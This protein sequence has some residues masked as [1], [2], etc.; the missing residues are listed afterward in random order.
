MTRSSQKGF[1]LTEVVICL[2][3]GSMV[4]GAVIKVMISNDVTLKL[5][6][7]LASVQENGRFGI[8]R[9]RADLLYTGMYQDRPEAPADAFDKGEEAQFVRH[10]PVILPGTFTKRPQLGSLQGEAGASDTLVVARQSRRDCRGYTLGYDG[11][12]PVFI[13]NEYYVEGTALKCRGFDGRFLRGQKDAEGHNRHAGF[14]LLDDVYSFQVLYGQLIMADENEPV[15]RYVTADNIVDKSRIVS[16]RLAL[17][18]KGDG[19]VFIDP[20]PAFSLLNESPFTPDENRLFKQFET[21]IT[22]RNVLYMN[23]LQHS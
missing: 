7:A 8:A 20:V 4:A 2:L 3:L 10:H 11:Q 16:L 1:T 12:Q 13:V 5:N 14:T 22:L 9:L 18:L 23:G 21:T 6:Q 15:L 17:L 19:E